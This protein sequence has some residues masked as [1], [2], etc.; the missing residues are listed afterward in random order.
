MKKTALLHLITM[1]NYI[2]VGFISGAISHGFFTAW[3]SVMMAALGV[4][5]FIIATYI[6]EVKIKKTD[7]TKALIISLFTGL[8]FSLG[9]G[10]VS[11]WLQHFL[12]SPERSIRIIPLGY[13]VSLA[14][15]PIKEH[16]DHPDRKKLL[17][18][19][20]VV[21]VLLFIATRGVFTLLSKNGRTP[22]EHE[23]SENH[24]E[25][26]MSDEHWIE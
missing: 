24:I 6:Q 9:V 2:G 21:S 22:L 20:I 3:R 4:L 26:W 12:D 13:F 1:L 11:G 25:A 8:I 18:F 17:G 19:G 16:I 14:I 7:L 23:E 15:F 10:L 5:L